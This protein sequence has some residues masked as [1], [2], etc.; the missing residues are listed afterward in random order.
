MPYVGNVYQLPPGS[1]ATP[2]TPIESAPYNTFLNDITT[3]QNTARP[4]IGGGTGGV[5]AV[6]GNDGLNAQG[7]NI[8]SGST[9]DLGAA[10]GVYLNVT[11][12][13]TINSFGTAAAGAER[14]LTFTGILQLTYNATSMILPGAANVTTAVGDTATFRSLGGGNW[15]CVDYL[16]ASGQAP[17]NVIVSPNITGATTI[18]T[19]A[20]GN[21]LTLTSTD[22]GATAGPAVELFRDSASPAASDIGGYVYFTGRNSA[23]TKK[24]LAEVIVQ[25]QDVTAGSEDAIVILRNIIAGAINTA[26]TLGAGVYLGSATGGDKGAGTLNATALYQ[27]GAALILQKSFESSQ[28]TITA[29]GAL[30]L[31]HGLGASPKLISVSLVCQTIDSGYAVNDEVFINHHMNTSADQGRGVSIVPDATNL[32][33]RFGSNAATLTIL[34]KSSGVQGNI[35]NSRWKLVIRAWA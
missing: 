23:A 24:I 11:G 22:A 29:G 28:Q 6:A 8:A 32:N 9:T 14:V 18:T 12:T 5:T 35:V 26:V 17:T 19:T 20:A 1:T 31:A 2:N 10:T 30:T 27:N 13:T 33:V 15:R 4:V 21:I 34:D 25:S 3:A 7:A 16:R